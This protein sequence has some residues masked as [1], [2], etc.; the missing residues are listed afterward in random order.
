MSQGTRQA[1]AKLTELV[2]TARQEWEHYSMCC[3]YDDQAAT[4]RGFI[5]EYLT[6]Y[7][8]AAWC[9][10]RGHEWIDL[11][12]GDPEFGPNPCVECVRCGKEA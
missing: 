2:K 6:M 9:G 7:L 8:G 11:D 3:Y 4:F 12:I 1:A 5:W 10:F